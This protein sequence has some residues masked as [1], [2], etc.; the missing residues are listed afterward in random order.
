MGLMDYRARFYD[1]YISQFSQPNTVVQ[2]QY[3][4]LDWNRYAY[5]RWNPVNF[6]DPSS[7]DVGC[8]AANPA[9]QAQN[10]EEPKKETEPLIT[11]DDEN[12]V[13]ISGLDYGCSGTLQSYW[14]FERDTNLPMLAH[15]L[16]QAVGTASDF[17]ADPLNLG[18][19]GYEKW[20]GINLP[21]KVGFGVDAGIQ[22][23]KDARRDDLNPLQRGG[24]A[25]VS[26]LEGM[27][28]SAAS[29]TAG[30]VVGDA[31]LSASF[32][33]AV[34]TGQLWV[35]P[36]A[37]WVGFTSTYLATN[38]AVGNAFEYFNAKVVYPT[39]NLGAP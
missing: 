22:V 24:R 19:D 15:D 34:E 21:K 38:Y 12:G 28:T 26:G 17:A 31:A 20:H 11:V 13:C 7:H 5:V 9:C 14:E 23:L 6:N 8:T 33:P 39:F 32:A 16:E 29:T 35:P 27:A 3:N 1:P 30:G 10:N 36:V 25:V 37:Y 4:P 2:D 18:L